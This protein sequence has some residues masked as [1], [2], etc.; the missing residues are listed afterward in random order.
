M[1]GLDDRFEILLNDRV[2]KTP[3]AISAMA[4]WVDAAYVEARKDHVGAA[5]IGGYSV[6]APTLQ[7]SREMAAGGRE[8]FLP[9]DPLKELERQV[10]RLERTGV[11]AGVNLRAASPESFREAA[12]ALGDR[13]VYEI[14]AH[15]RQEPMV[16][17]G[18]GEYLLHHTGIL[19]EHVR[20]LA[21]EGV[22][23][24]VKI[25]AGVAKDDAALGHRL[26]K[27]GASVLHVDLMD[28]G[29][30][31]IR[32]IRN[33]SPVFLIAN[34]SM[35]SF[36]RVM[37]MFSHGADMVSLARRSDPDTLAG[38][39]AAIARY[40]DEFGWFNAP[41][42]L[43]RGGDVRALT[44]CCLP[45]KECPL[46]PT[47]SRL[48]VSR[49]EYIRMKQEA[50]RG[51]PL[52]S[53]EYTCFGSMAWCCKATSPCM[54]RDSSMQMAGLTTKEYMRLKRHLS[55]TIMERIFGGRAEGKQ[56]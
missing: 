20:G 8:E 43:C 34:N 36:D 22:T 17:A 3:I 40:A 38:I 39:D 45:V 14:D 18:C 28:F 42:Q 10:E 47:L 33:T 2:V 12:R 48:G 49:E 5:F 35:H 13:A 29:Y 53:G 7:A 55:Q 24:S 19:E 4:G 11:V 41:K 52:E 44:F 9:D 56:G 1:T 30:A 51:T 31:K 54:L 37:E 25:R 26:W 32:Q 27:A 6:D 50:V 16:R 21:K 46:I 23:V 15:C